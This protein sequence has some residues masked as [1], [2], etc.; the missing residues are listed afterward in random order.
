MHFLIKLNLT[1]KHSWKNKRRLYCL[2]LAS[3]A[4]LGDSYKKHIYGGA[5]LECKRLFQTQGKKRVACSGGEGM[6]R[7]EILV[8]G[9]KDL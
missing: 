9:I 6:F 5:S 7:S 2:K 3:W 8:L 1:L 4:V